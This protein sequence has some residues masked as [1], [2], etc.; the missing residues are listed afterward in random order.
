MQYNHINKLLKLKDVYVKNIILKN[1]STEIHIETKATIHNCPDCGHGT[2]RIHDYRKQKIKDL[3][4]H[5]QDTFLILRKRRYLCTSCGKKF[6]ESYSF[7]PKYHRMTTR[8]I[9]SIGNELHELYNMKMI[10]AKHNVTTPT[11]TRILN[12]INHPKPKLPKVLCIDEFKGNA[13]TGK[14]QAILVDGKRHKVLDIL[15]T[16]STDYLINY[17]ME[18]PRKERFSVEYFICD[19]W[20]PYKEIAASLFPNAKIIVDKYHFVRQIGWALESV[21]K[22]AQKT[23]P[24]SLRKY[25]KRSR[26]LLLADFNTLNEEN[27][28]AV[29][30]MLLYHDDLR[31]AH[32]L[33]ELFHQIRSENSYVKQRT[34]IDQWI[35]YAEKSNIQ[36]FVKLATTYRKWRTYILN[37]YKYGYTNGPTEG[38][39]NKIKVLKRISFGLRNF[40]RYRNRILLTCN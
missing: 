18:C 20:M 7:L 32:Y 15:P 29:E 2:S 31:Q 9:H 12:T 21:R 14:F 13:E 5:F 16:R 4:Y 17:F 28:K 11:V 10:A 25:Y 39:N 27:K 8:L 40:N 19:M 30:I 3:P 1:N 24:A 37:A 38:F 34:L 23:M 33:K 35:K 26:K 22:T 36:A 6:Y